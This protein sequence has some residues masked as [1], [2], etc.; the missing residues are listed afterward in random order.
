MRRVR[1]EATST[2]QSECKRNRRSPRFIQNWCCLLWGSKRQPNV[3]KEREARLFFHSMTHERSHAKS[4]SRERLRCEY[5]PGNLCCEA[6]Q[7]DC[8]PLC[9]FDAP[10]LFHL[11]V[12]IRDTVIDSCQNPR[13]LHK[14]S[15][16]IGSVWAM[17]K[18]PQNCYLNACQITA[19]F[20]QSESEHFSP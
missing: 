17:R 20:T 8:C 2:G 15:V 13:F 4:G 3:H 6:N 16:N 10:A 7:A 11:N 12:R 9:R 18:N 5:P 14:V 19:G 1:Y